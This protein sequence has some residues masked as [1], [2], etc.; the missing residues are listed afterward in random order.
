MST[1]RIAAT[2]Y[3]RRLAD[4]L[5]VD[6]RS[7]TPS[8]SDG[9]R[10]RDVENA[11]RYR[12]KATPLSK[13]VALGLGVG[14]DTVHGSG[15]GGKITKADVLAAAAAKT[16]KKTLPGEVIPLTSMR[17]VIA[18]R[19]CASHTEIPPVTS[20]VKV[21]VTQL[22]EFRQKL[23][24]GREKAQRIT[25]NDLIIRATA[26]ALLQH[27][28]FRM[29]IDG[30]NYIVNEHIN[31]GV[32]VGIDDGLLVP[33]IH[34]VDKKTIDEISA[35]AKLLAGKAKTGALR[36][37]NMGGGCISISNLGMF[38]TYLFTPIVNQPEAAILG[39]CSTEDELALVDGAVVV[40]KKMMV[41]L[42]FDHRIING[43]EASKFQAELKRILET[44]EEIIS[45][46]AG[47]SYGD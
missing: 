25:V 19:M 46:I 35:E 16:T 47:G 36:P 10:G 30:G 34:D 13:A 28:R 43:T 4:E 27:K 26:K 39:I 37:E 15:Y 21:D 29:S 14:L 2:P 45:E 33:V 41:C 7:V 8:C 40:R 5:G 44:P 1:L 22:L 31:I 20:V 3:A 18:K 32:A 6:L 12:I 9:I 17:K 24:E 38:G 42:T 23:N 11:K